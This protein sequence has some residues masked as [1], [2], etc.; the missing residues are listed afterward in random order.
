MPHNRFFSK[1]EFKLKKDIE[2]TDEEFFHLK[3]VTRLKEKETVEI[4]NGKGQLAKGIIK[5]IAKDK[6]IVEITKVENSSKNPY[7]IIL[8]QGLPLRKN[9]ELIIEKA[10]EIGIDEIRIFTSD[11]TKKSKISENDKL[12]LER[13]TISAL[14]Q[15]GRTFLPT[16][17][18]FSKISDLNLKDHSVFLCDSNLNTKSD[19]NIPKTNPIAIIVGPESGLSNKEKDF[20]K[21]NYDHQIIKFNSNTLRCETASI[22]I[23]SIVSYLIQN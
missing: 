14:K 8:C 5:K 9:L 2:L 1:E 6:S 23:C 10:T 16:I 3:N 13:I 4:V 21:K 12:R 15:C 18:F 19:I 17:S 11:N 7:P 20:I 22:A